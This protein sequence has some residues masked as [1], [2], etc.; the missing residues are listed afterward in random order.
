MQDKSDMK[1]LNL[2]GKEPE[3][4]RGEPLFSKFNDMKCSPDNPLEQAQYLLLP[5]YVLGFAL[6]KKEW[7]KLLANSQRNDCRY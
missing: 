2:I 3:D 5:G 7:G 6:G 1:M 4:T